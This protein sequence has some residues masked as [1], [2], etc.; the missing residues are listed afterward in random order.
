MRISDVLNRKGNRTHS[1]KENASMASAIG[2]MAKKNIGSVVV[3]DESNLRPVGI[4]SE[5][6]IVSTLHTLGAPGLHHTLKTLMRVPPPTCSTRS[7]VGEALA[8]MTR[9]RV[10]YLI[11]IDDDQRLAGLVSIGDLVKARLESTELETRVLR[12][13]ARASLFASG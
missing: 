8:H 13:M 10:R 11:A 2:L 12:D 1:L 6:D 4:I 3:L 7:S 5:P 9:D